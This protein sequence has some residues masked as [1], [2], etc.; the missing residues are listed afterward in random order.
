[1]TGRAEELA[2]LFPGS[3]CD[4]AAITRLVP[5]TLAMKLFL[6]APMWC[7]CRSVAGRRVGEACQSIPHTIRMR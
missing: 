4:K 6:M 1:M 3:H 7:N 5:A 2:P